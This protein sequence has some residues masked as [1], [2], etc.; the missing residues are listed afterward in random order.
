MTSAQIATPA[1]A[2]PGERPTSV[3]LIDLENHVFA[4]DHKATV[5]DV[6]NWWEFYCN[7]VL[8]IGPN[9]VVF[10]GVSVKNLWMK[11]A[12]PWRK[13]LFWVVGHAGP[14]GADQAILASVYPPHAAL[15]YRRA[16]VVSGDGAFINF[17]VR[18]KQAGMIVQVVAVEGNLHPNLAKAASIRT[19]IRRTSRRQ[20]EINTSRLEAVHAAT[21]A[22]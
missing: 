20:K 16:V 6:A 21:F 12:I 4:T 3:H 19:T 9:D 10:L 2:S 22:A 14:N 7:E 17:A 5:R 15:T 1:N 11:K 18:A 13:N 8:G